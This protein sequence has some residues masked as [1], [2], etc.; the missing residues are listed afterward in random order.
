MSFS[1]SLFLPL[2]FSFPC[3]R[4]KWARMPETPCLFGNQTAVFLKC[5]EIDCGFKTSE[6]PALRGFVGGPRALATAVLYLVLLSN[7]QIRGET[8]RNGA[9]PGGKHPSPKARFPTVERYSPGPFTHRPQT[10][11][12]SFQ[13]AAAGTHAPQPLTA[14]TAAHTA[15][16]G[17]FSLPATARLC[18]VSEIATERTAGESGCTP[19]GVCP[20][21]P[22]SRARRHA[23]P[24]R[25]C[26]RSRECFS[27]AVFVPTVSSPAP[28][29]VPVPLET[30]VRSRGDSCRSAAGR[31]PPSSAPAPPAPPR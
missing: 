9:W 22:A 28:A 24:G 11:Q 27:L 25:C 15:K 13:G 18:A 26:F 10:P 31:T 16:Q 5:A 12:R 4:S 8:L 29:A 30:A 17:A 21:S 6:S 2:V 1:F 3:R 7:G 19:Y 20:L 23:Q 14:H